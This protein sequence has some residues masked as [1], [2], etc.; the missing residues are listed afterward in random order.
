VVEAAAAADRAGG[1]G[2]PGS[3]AAGSCGDAEE[4]VE[5][6]S[7]RTVERLRG[8]ET[9]ELCCGH[10]QAHPACDLWA[11]GAARDEPGL[12]DVCMLKELREG[13]RLTKLKRQ[14]I[15]SG[16]AGGDRRGKHGW[17]AAL[18]A[19]GRPQSLGPEVV[20]G[21]DKSCQG[22]VNVTGYGPMKVASAEW[23]RPG[24]RGR[25]VDV[26]H[27]RSVRPRLNSRGYLADNCSEGGA[28]G[29]SHAVM[30]L[31]GKTFRYTAD[32]S[33][34]G[35]GCGAG[36]RLAPPLQTRR[37]GGAAPCSDWRHG[38]CAK[39]DGRQCPLPCPGIVL[40]MANQYAWSSSL[41]AR[42]DALGASTG[43]GGRV[44]NASGWSA[45]TY[46]PGSECIDT[47]WPFEV[48]V[49]FPVNEEG[50]LA[51]M[52]V[53]LSQ[54]GK[55][56][57]LAGHVRWYD[58]P[59][60][61]DGIKELSELLSEGMTPV[62]EYVS[63]S[64]MMWLDGARGDGAGPCVRDAPEACAD[65]VR[66]YG[67]AVEGLAGGGG[68][69]KDRGSLLS[70]ALF[71]IHG[72]LATE[73]SREQR[74]ERAAQKAR[75]D[76]ERKA[77]I[78]YHDLSSELGTGSC[79][80]AQE[81]GYDCWWGTLPFPVCEEQCS[82]TEACLGFDF[83]F[84]PENCELRFSKGS[85]PADNPG[86]FND[87]WSDGKGA[88]NITGVVDDGSGRK[89]YVKK[90]ITSHQSSTME[91]F[92]G[93]SEWEV[94]YHGNDMKV[95]AEPTM[96]GKV[97]GVKPSGAI[98]VGEPMGGGQ[99]DTLGSSQWLRLAHE[100]GYMRMSLREIGDMIRERR[101]TYAK[102]SR[103]TCADMGLYTIIDA[104]TCEA[105]GFA[106]GY[107]DTQVET[108]RGT[109][110][111]PWGCHLKDGSL[112]VA[113]QVGE[114]ELS[115]PGAEPLCASEDYVTTTTTTSTTVTTTTS[116]RTSS[117]STISTSTSTTSTTWGWPSFFC[118]EVVRVDCYEADMVRTQ[119]ERRVSIFQCEHYTVFSN[120]GVVALGEGWNSTEIPAPEVS[121]GDL[122]AGATTNS[123]LNTMIFIKAWEMVR[124]DGRYALHDWTV[125]ADPDAVFFPQRLRGRVAQH[126]PEGR[127]KGERLFYVNCDLWE[128]V[129]MYGSLEIFSR[130]AL[131][132][133]YGNSER[134]TK[135]LDW[136]GWGEDFFMQKCM[137]LLKV[138]HVSDFEMIGD[139]RCHPASCS[140]VSKVAFHDFKDVDGWFGCW[141][142]STRSAGEPIPWESAGGDDAADGEQ[143]RF[144]NR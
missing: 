101:V 64:D 72:S 118:Y 38:P 104:A 74:A 112:Y 85:M 52:E 116:T 84:G 34:A 124:W 143:A 59:N 83:Q 27:N 102:V 122:S 88:G 98:V 23:A 136:Q 28:E 105:A 5:Y 6:H 43:F 56:C 35:C 73:E 111:R 129:A 45:E 25:Q 110:T 139:N 37:R 126:T 100:P 15:V 24:Q 137:E 49:S 127:D 92:P 82:S 47:S 97:I 71:R 61:V 60:G 138:D 63:S 53:I 114:K 66:F 86:P 2:D 20:P 78:T 11:W 141:S 40:Q 132:H 121:M 90:W 142:E 41:H 144:L 19:S 123:W 51:A 44:G 93:S 46:R 77:R 106:L 31:L 125:K 1:A 131:D 107:F 29:A 95:R 57:P 119:L 68:G 120:G 108:Y 113:E 135:E 133:Y 26:E 36:V 8:V 14:G 58:A 76:V 70:A 103:G 13:D 4:G 42:G 18:L 117:T 30:N 3:P 134:C 12:S 80:D 39:E 9:R 32:L 48:A 94:V 89:C 128:K 21:S 22:S 16:L 7:P 33:G 69:Q 10:C 130:E 62:I 87:S 55:D 54:D 50:T 140:D 81:E 17:V 99:K 109:E 79:A 91:S 67:F 75:A 65:A 115:V 96:D